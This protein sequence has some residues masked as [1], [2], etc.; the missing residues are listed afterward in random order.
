MKISDHVIR[1][2][3]EMGI[4]KDPRV[5]EVFIQNLHLLKESEI[6]KLTPTDVELINLLTC[7]QLGQDHPFSRWKLIPARVQ[8]SSPGY[9]YFREGVPK[10]WAR[11]CTRKVCSGAEYTTDDPAQNDLLKISYVQPFI[12]AHSGIEPFC[13]PGV[14]RDTGQSL[15]S[16]GCGKDKP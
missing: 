15:F 7:G 2:L 9:F 4:F 13:S 3:A 8:H 14:D 1:C 10:H 6:R 12:K 11:Y 16:G 5:F